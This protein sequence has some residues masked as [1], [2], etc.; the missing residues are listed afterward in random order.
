MPCCL[1]AAVAETMCHGRGI[2]YEWCVQ[3]WERAEL[4]FTLFV[5]FSDTSDGL[6]FERLSGPERCTVEQV[7][8]IMRRC[9]VDSVTHMYAE[10][11]DRVEQDKFIGSA[12]IEFFRQ[13]D[14]AAADRYARYRE[15]FY[16]RRD[17]QE[18]A[19]ALARQAEE[20]ARREKEQAELVA[21]KAQYFGWADDMT[22]LRF[23]QV[24]TLMD[25]SVRVDGK[26]M[27]RREFVVNCIKGGW[28]PQKKEGVTSWYRR[29][30]EVKESKPRTEYQ[31]YKDEYV[32]KITKTEYDFAVF[33]AGRNIASK[34]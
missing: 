22:S 31:L 17:Q 8:D 29:G 2:C 25:T 4:E 20:D 34:A 19:R 15:N 3:I 16:A 13:F 21:E 14:S 27:T 11:N 9:R 18:R 1:N 6:R 7:A 24:S 33:L 10:L 28:V 23:G 30:R 5:F 12:Q 32:Y 26:M